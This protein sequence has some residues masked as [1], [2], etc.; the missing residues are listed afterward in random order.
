MKKAA[1]FAKNSGCL[2]KTIDLIKSIISGEARMPTVD[3]INMENAQALAEK[4]NENV[5]VEQVKEAMDQTNLT[6]KDLSNAASFVK[7]VYNG[8]K[9]SDKELPTDIAQKTS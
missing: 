9:S 8:K 5:D 2:D 3:D 1:Q 4:I 6:K 7:D